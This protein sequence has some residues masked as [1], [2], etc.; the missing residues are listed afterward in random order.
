MST[1]LIESWLD[2]AMAV[3]DEIC[4]AGE[5]WAKLVTQGQVFRIV[6][7]E[8]NQAVDTLFFNVAH[9]V[10]R[11]SATVTIRLLSLLYLTPVTHLNSNSGLCHLT[12]RPVPSGA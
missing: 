2:P 6:D 12:Y 11:Y 5:P 1:N 8:G 3:V 9:S 4:A 10:E 7:L